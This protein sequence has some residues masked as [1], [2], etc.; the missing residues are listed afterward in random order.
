M[1]QASSGQARIRPTILSALPFLP[2]GLVEM[3]SWVRCESADIHPPPTSSASVV[4]PRA[5]H[6]STAP[7]ALSSNLTLNSSRASQLD[8]LVRH[9]TQ[10]FPREL[11]LRN[12]SSC[13]FIL[14]SHLSHLSHLTLPS[15]NSHDKHNQ[16][17]AHF[18]HYF[19]V[20]LPLLLHL[21]L[22]PLP[23][24]GRSKLELLLLLPTFYPS[25]LFFSSI[26]LLPFKTFT[27]TSPPRSLQPY[28]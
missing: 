6:A 13:S 3:P 1:Y 11:E 24:I 10:G 25:Q 9:F 26:T 28:I 8:Q 15:S 2:P 14:P 27:F 12:R 7:S 18:G 22:L 20:T 19:Y 17:Q 5:S 23:L 16:A 4:P 21:L